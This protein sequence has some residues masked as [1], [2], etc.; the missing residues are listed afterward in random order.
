MLGVPVRS[1]P[2]DDAEKH[3]GHFAAAVVQHENRASNRKEVEQL[4]WQ[5]NG[6]DFLSDVRSGSYRELAQRLR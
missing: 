2:Y 4:G 5:S 1:V 3:L 6:I